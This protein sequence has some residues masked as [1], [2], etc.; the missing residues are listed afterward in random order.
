VVSQKTE[1]KWT[2]QSPLPRKS[3]GVPSL[4]YHSLCLYH[5]SLSF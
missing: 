2:G 1:L 5:F 4:L 3:T